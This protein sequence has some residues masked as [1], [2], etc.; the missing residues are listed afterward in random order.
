MANS[1]RDGLGKL[2]VFFL[3]FA[4]LDAI[5]TASRTST[6][7]SVPTVPV[8]MCTVDTQT[9]STTGIG[10][11]SVGTFVPLAT[12]SVPKPSP[13]H[14]HVCSSSLVFLGTFAH[15][16]SLR[17]KRKTNEYISFLRNMLPEL[18][19]KQPKL[20]NSSI[21]RIASSLYRQR[22]VQQNASHS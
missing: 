22:K 9:P 10:V 17:K 20:S 3:M 12:L 2:N 6:S 16:G 8:A 7:I 13:V 15:D 14:V 5:T 11:V 1:F 4:S 18:K 21:L 19:R